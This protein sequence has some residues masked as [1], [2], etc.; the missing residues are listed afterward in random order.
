MSLTYAAWYEHVTGV[1]CGHWKTLFIYLSV[2]LGSV[3]TAIELT[4]FFC[5]NWMTNK[6][7]ILIAMLIIC[8]SVALFR[9]IHAYCLAVPVG[10]ENE[11]ALAQKI[12]RWKRPFWESALAHELMKCRIREPDQELDDIM[13]NRIHVPITRS[14]DVADY[15]QWLETRP[16]NLLRI[17]ETEKQL[18][19][20]ELASALTSKGAGIEI[21][22][23]M[24]GAV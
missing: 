22:E 24:E 17:L 14:M 6:R 7:P 9:C 18:L 21:S 12:A 5:P 19:V 20:V 1:V 15:S 23:L 4:D 13:N 10:L 3:W 11:S 16:A 8:A 2:T